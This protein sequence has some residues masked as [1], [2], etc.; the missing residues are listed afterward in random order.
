MKGQRED[1]PGA[2]ETIMELQASGGGRGIYHCLDESDVVRIMKHPLGMVGSDG[3]AVRFGT[4]RVHPRN[5]GSFP[6]VLSDYVRERKVLTLEAAVRKMTALPAER[7]GLSDRGRIAVGMHADLV[8]FH[9]DSV[10]DRATFS[11]PH[12]YPA[13]IDGVLVNGIFVVRNETTTGRRPGTVLR[14]R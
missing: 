12:Q 2:A 8:I 7:L 11:D 5:Y 4:G 6:R 14:N 10:D 9:P 1:I 3:G 13:G